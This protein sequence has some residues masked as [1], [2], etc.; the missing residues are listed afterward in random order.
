MSITNDTHQIPPGWCIEILQAA[1]LVLDDIMDASETRRG[2]PCWYKKVEMMA[3]NDGIIL[4]SMVW[5][6]LKKHF[7]RGRSYGAENQI[8]NGNGENPNGEVKSENNTQTS[9]QLSQL[10][11]QTYFELTDLFQ[12]TFLLTELGQLM[13]TRCEE[14]KDLDEL[15]SADRWEAVV[16]YKT[17]FYSFYHPVAS[18]MI[19]V[20]EEAGRKELNKDFNDTSSDNDRM[21]A[22]FDP[23]ESSFDFVRKV[24][25]TLGR[26]FQAQDDF[27]DCFADPEVLGKIGTDICDR[28]CSW[29]LQKA[30]PLMNEEQ[31]EYFKTFYGK[32]EVGSAQERKI[33]D[34]YKELEM[35][36]I[37]EQT[38]EDFVAEIRAL[39]AE[40]PKDVPWE[41]LEDFLGKIYKRSK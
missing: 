4:E 1:F 15:A 18:A 16:T 21:N 41:A 2:R 22:T 33:K 35:E 9:N 26:Y 19:L 38:E 7:Y 25:V 40:C 14:I 30:W 20:R 31:K 3:V 17:A 12:D 10:H 23:S 29:L 34:I 13:D 27:L 28:K 5:R 11:K 6:C 32:C 24:C 36:K 8:H 39:Q 37:W